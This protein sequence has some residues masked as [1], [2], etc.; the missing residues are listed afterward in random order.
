[1]QTIFITQYELNVYNSYLPTITVFSY[2]KNNC[3]STS[4]HL[5]FIDKILFFNLG[6]FLS[7]INVKKCMKIG[8]SII[9]KL[10]IEGKYNVRSN[11][12]S[13]LLPEVCYPTIRFLS[14]PLF[15]RIFEIF[16][17]LLTSLCSWSLGAEGFGADCSLVVSMIRLSD[18]QFPSKLFVHE[19]HDT[20][21][22][23]KFVQQHCI[24][25]SPIQS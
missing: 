9:I 15:D 10:W 25:G 13:V 16:Y 12:W 3:P 6:R 22:F 18:F 11:F 1:M 2:P 21:Y 14:K 20:G 24:D 5:D 4:N 19:D 17:K 23:A 7:I 8:E